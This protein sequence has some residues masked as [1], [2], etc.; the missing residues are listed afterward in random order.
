MLIVDTHCSDMCCNEFR[1]PQTDRKSKQVKEHSD[2]KILFAI[3]MG[4]TRYLKTYK[5][6]ISL[7]I[8]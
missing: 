6:Y 1:V 7:G 8:I 3:S 5:L 4:K 2:M